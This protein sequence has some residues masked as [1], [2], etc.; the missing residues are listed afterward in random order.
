[1]TC[2]Q[3]AVVALEDNY[4]NVHLYGINSIKSVQ[5][6]FIQQAFNIITPK[7]VALRMSQSQDY[8]QNSLI[9]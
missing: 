9:V 3:T 2:A 1:M 5:M 4:S 7:I 6:C 8:W